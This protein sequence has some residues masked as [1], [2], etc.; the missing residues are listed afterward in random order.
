MQLPEQNIVAEQN[1][2]YQTGE[3]AICESCAMGKQHKLPYPKSS[4]TARTDIKGV[5]HSD[6]CGSMTVPSVGDSKNFLIYIDDLTRNIC[7]YYMKQE[8]KVLDKFK[9]H[10][11]LMSNT[12]GK[13][14]K[15]L[16]SDNGGECCSDIFTHYVKQQ[17]YQSPNNYT[18]HSCPKRTCRAYESHFGEVCSINDALQKCLHS[19]SRQ[20]QLILLYI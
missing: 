17:R 3:K 16:Q 7:M 4:S 9:E 15:V 20:E 19:S 8:S 1:S 2:V 6:V 13:R 5:V 14:D 10:V 12:T 18:T 11:N